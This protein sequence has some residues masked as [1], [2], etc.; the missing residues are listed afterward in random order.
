[1]RAGGVHPLG[2]MPIVRTAPEIENVLL[3]PVAT[4]SVWLLYER[5]VALPNKFW[6]ESGALFV[7]RPSTVNVNEELGEALP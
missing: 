4:R 2:R 3:S 6:V 5:S 1:M 7:G